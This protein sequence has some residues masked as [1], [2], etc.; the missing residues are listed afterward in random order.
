MPHVS[1][2]SLRWMQEM[3]QFAQS[4]FGQNIEFSF[5]LGVTFWLT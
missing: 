4:T 5:I 3:N 2:L 1:S